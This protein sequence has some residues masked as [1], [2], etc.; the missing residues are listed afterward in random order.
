M[1]SHQKYLTLL[2]LLTFGLISYETFSQR[3]E[4]TKEKRPAYLGVSFG[5]SYSGFR[6]L[7]T[8]PLVYSGFPVYAALS[9]LEQDE[10]RA[11]QITL[12]YAFGNYENTFNEQNSASQVN[13]ISVS[14]SELFQMKKWSSPKFNLQVGGQFNATANL[15][16]NEDLFNNSEGVDMIFTLF[17]TARATIDLSRNAAKKRGSNLSYTLNVGLVNSSYR[18]GFAYLSSAVPINEDQ[19]FADYELNVFS[20]FRLKSALA[21]TIFLRNKNAI[22]LSYLWDAY[23]TGGHHDKLEMATHTLKCSL[24]FGLR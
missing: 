16:N 18:N 7:A 17:G 15:R 3:S 4:V 12:A 24:L 20:G 5:L 22:Q 9:H 8:S 1:R 6:D 2:I 14:Y 11:S 13:T 23:T 21:Y 19:F 10:K